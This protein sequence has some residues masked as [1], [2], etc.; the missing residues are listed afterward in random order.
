MKKTFIAGWIV[1]IV[2]A[3]LFALGY[4][5]HGNKAIYM[6]NNKPVIVNPK[7]KTF[8]RQVKAFKNLKVNVSEVDVEI[9]T[10]DKFNVKYVGDN[11]HEPTVKLQ[12]ETLT[13]AQ[14]KHNPHF[15]HNVSFR[16]DAKD[17]IVFSDKTNYKNKLVVTI[18]EDTSIDELNGRIDDGKVTLNN[19]TM[20]NTKLSLAESELNLNHAQ[21][22]NVKITADDTDMKF[23]NSNL[24]VGNIDTDNGSII[25][26]RGSLRQ[27]GIKVSDGDVTIDNVSLEGGNLD[28][29]NGDININNTQVQAGYQIKNI[30]GDLKVKQ[31]TAEGYDVHVID[32]SVK[33]F[34][35]TK[36]D[37][38]R[39]DKNA[40]SQ[41]ILKVQVE[42]GDADVN[43]GQE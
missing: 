18:P 37:G 41:N 7:K 1:L 12:N 4:S 10:G 11:Y 36:E 33:L 24:S 43:G 9:K 27:V 21:L 29:E 31:T 25:F 40:T 32:G 42:D 6:Q 23:D 15:R 8:N 35:S 22:D 19:V 34:K 13:L 5:L 26:N 39:L 14:T 3:L 20:K 28:V 17:G 38:G 2:G 16:I 30:D